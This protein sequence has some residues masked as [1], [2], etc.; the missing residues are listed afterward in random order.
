MADYQSLRTV[1]HEEIRTWAEARGGRPAVVAGT[2]DEEGNGIL[3]IDFGAGEEDLEEVS[4][5]EFFRIFEANGLALVYLDAVEGDENFFHKFI[6]R[7]EEEPADE[8][9]DDPSF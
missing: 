6:A 9:L 7:A 3:R 1:D 5:P 2:R 8:Y 4:W